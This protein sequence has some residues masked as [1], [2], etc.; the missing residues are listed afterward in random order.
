MPVRRTSKLSELMIYY[1]YM[2]ALQNE[3]LLTEMKNSLQ[4]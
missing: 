2:T 1:I 3:K 4:F